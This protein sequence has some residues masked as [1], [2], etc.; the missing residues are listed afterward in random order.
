MTAHRFDVPSGAGRSPRAHLLAFLTVALLLIDAGGLTRA[1]PGTPA[2]S[3]AASPQA[4]PAAT[5]MA[6]HRSTQ[7]I[8]V[9]EVT[10]ELTDSGFNPSHFE[11]AVGRN[12]TI[13]LVNIGTRPHNFTMPAFREDGRL[14]LTRQRPLQRRRRGGHICA[15]LTRWTPP[16]SRA[17]SCEEHWLVYGRNHFPPQFAKR[18]A[19]S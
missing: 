14:H 9:G 13:K 15:R 12:V 5:P 17:T 1:A 18:T 16:D 4:A 6:P 3:P 2:A 8:V 10:V 19:P 11:S 7:T